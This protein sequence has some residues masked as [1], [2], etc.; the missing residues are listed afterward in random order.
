MVALLLIAHGSRDPAWAE[1]FRALEARIRAAHRGPVEL[2][3]LETMRPDFAEGA[4]RLAEAGAAR[5]VVVPLFLATGS[6]VRTDIPA[7]VVEARAAHP[8]VE[9]SM[10]PAIGLIDAVQAAMGEAILG[11]VR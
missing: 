1:P 11:Q 9:F 8:D 3:Y 4:R 6:H 5:V 2:V 7:K 10:L